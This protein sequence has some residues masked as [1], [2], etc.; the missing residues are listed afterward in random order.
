MLF[1]SINFS[2]EKDSVVFSALVNYVK[3]SVYCFVLLHLC[4]FFVIIK[5]SHFFSLAHVFI[6]SRISFKLG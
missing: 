4:L 5:F 3:V 2:L 1:V 6:R